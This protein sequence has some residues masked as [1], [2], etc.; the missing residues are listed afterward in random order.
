MG[1]IEHQE[2]VIKKLSCTHPKIK[3]IWEYGGC[4]TIPTSGELVRYVSLLWYEGN[5]ECR[6]DFKDNGDG[7]AIIEAEIFL[8]TLPIN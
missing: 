1:Y 8:S 2:N 6:R 4:A 7:K 3:K 5:T